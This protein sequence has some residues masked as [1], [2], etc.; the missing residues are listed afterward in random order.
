MRKH[1]SL[2]TEEK[3]PV[4]LWNPKD[5]AKTVVREALCEVIDDLLKVSEKKTV[6]T[7]ALRESLAKIGGS[8]DLKPVLA[9]IDKKLDGLTANVSLERDVLERLKAKLSG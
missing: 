1:A 4:K 7:A 6:E 2:K 3:K 8:D 5:V 9:S